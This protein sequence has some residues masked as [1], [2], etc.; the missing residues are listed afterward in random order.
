LFK[1]NLKSN[2]KNFDIPVSNLNILLILI[3][4]Q[5]YFSYLYAAKILDLSA[6]PFLSLYTQVVPIIFSSSWI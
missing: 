3:I 6:K 4:Q 1:N 2:A 5:N